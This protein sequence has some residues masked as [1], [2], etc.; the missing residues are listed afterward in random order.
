MGRELSRAELTELLAAY[1]L[2]AL[3]GDERDQVEQFVARDADA[4]AEIDSLREAAA[5]LAHA[6]ETAPDGLWARIEESLGAAPP[7][8][9]L[10]AP[11]ALDARRARPAQRR[12]LALAAC[13]AAVAVAAIAVLG[14]EVSNQQGRIDQLD[15]RMADDG[16]R[17]AAE[18]AM[19]APGTQTVRLVSTDGK[20]V[21]SIVMRADGSAFF[22]GSDLPSLASGRTYQLWAI[23]GDAATPAPVS[24][25]VL[26]AH[27]T[28]TEFHIAGGVHMFAVTAE[29]SPGVAAPEH[30]PVLTGTMT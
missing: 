8:D 1:A 9:E 12:W 4:R 24:V 29:Q 21:A 26:G 27:A 7:S 20:H 25:A 22:M 30:A 5:F 15:R 14:L 17:R 2:D 28:L 23:S 6:G 18:S 16:M 3:D 19:E 13:F 10:G 11:V